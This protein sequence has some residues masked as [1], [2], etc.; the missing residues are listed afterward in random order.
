MEPLG[1]SLKMKGAFVQWAEPRSQ[2]VCVHHG[3][4]AA[5]TAPYPKPE[6]CPC[7]NLKGAESGAQELD[8]SHCGVQDPLSQQATA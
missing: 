3:L 1:R 7:L 8:V 2:R 6:G 4:S 5:V